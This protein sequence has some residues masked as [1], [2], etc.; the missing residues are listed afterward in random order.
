MKI[1]SEVK[2]IKNGKA[3]VNVR[4]THADYIAENAAH[5]EAILRA[6][7]DTDEKAFDL[8]IMACITDFMRGDRDDDCDD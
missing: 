2:N 7:H 1:E 5:F 3:N 8:A 4:I 6:M